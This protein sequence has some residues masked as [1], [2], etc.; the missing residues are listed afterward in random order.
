MTAFGS[1]GSILSTGG[2]PEGKVGADVEEVVLLSQD[3]CQAAPQEAAK[4][5]QPVAVAVLELFDSLPL[6]AV[7]RRYVD[8]TVQTIR[9]LNA[10]SLQTLTCLSLTVSRVSPTTRERFVAISS[11]AT[12]LDS[13]CFS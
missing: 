8:Q 3:A 7:W 1:G 2:N 6:T 13:F 9:N 4:M 10:Y 5:N 11:P 12:R